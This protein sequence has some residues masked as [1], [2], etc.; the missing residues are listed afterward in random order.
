MSSKTGRSPWHYTR[1][2]T[3]LVSYFCSWFSPLI[4]PP[5]P[6]RNKKITLLLR[7]LRRINNLLP[8]R[9]CSLQFDSSSA[10]SWKIHKGHTIYFWCE[11]V[12]A[13]YLYFFSRK[14]KLLFW[15]SFQTRIRIEV[16]KPIYH[17]FVFWFC[18]KTSIYMK[19]RNYV[20]LD[21]TYKYNF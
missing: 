6:L 7:V 13:R 4:S 2:S 10:D 9:S 18:K 17:L 16:P 11:I 19:G 21:S 14:L 3:N 15:K 12:F 20:Y 1:F 8:H 5:W